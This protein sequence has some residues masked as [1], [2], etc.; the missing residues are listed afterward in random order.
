MIPMSSDDLTD[1]AVVLGDSEV[2]CLQASWRPFDSRVI[3]YLAEL[4]RAI[5]ELPNIRDFPDLVSLAYW[6]RPSAIHR[7]EERHKD[8]NFVVG[9]GMVF[10]IPPSNVPLNFAYSLFCGLLSGNSNIVRLSS[11]ETAEVKELCQL[12]NELEADESLHEVCSRICLIRYEHNDQVTRFFSLKSSGRVIWGGNE[13]V[14][15][16]RGIES[17]LCS[18]DV[19]F[20]DRV[21]AALFCSS[22]VDELSEEELRRLVDSFIS[23]GY[24]FEQNACSSPR[25][26]MWQGTEDIVASASRKF[27][28]VLERRIEDKELISPAHHMMRFVELCELLASKDVSGEL[29]NVVGAATRIELIDG[30]EWKDYSRLRFG[31]FTEVTI[32]GLDNVTDFISRDVQTLGYF[33]F[34]SLEM[35]KMIEELKVD[36]I[37]RVVPIG[38]ALTFDTI[39][40]GYDLIR[41]LSRTV[42]VI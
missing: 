6:C 33:G 23:D 39:W 16:I 34:T 32:S 31:T 35:L 30:N 19:F 37:D 2:A 8:E 9:R 40:D 5:L 36:G 3:N 28:Q 22:K 38:S 11:T 26:L 27:W 17:A 4:S 41:T 1:V 14:R 24:T 10:H 21:S 20:A 7:L 42:M 15:K 25:L 12:M 13:T 18:V 29:R